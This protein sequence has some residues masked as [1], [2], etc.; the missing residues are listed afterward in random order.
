MEEPITP[1]ITARIRE[2]EKKFKK[3]GQDLG[4]H[5]DGLLHDR[6]LTY[7]DYIRLDTLLS[8]QVP[9]THFPDE[10]I[11]I[12]YHQI[13]ELYFKLVINELKQLI[14]EPT[15]TVK[16]FTERIRRVNRYFQV[17]T[18]SFEIMIK[19]MDREQFLQ[20]RL[21][22]MPASGFQSAQFR[23]IEIYTTPLYHLVS[24]ARRED[25]TIQS[26]LSEVYEQSYWK[27][28]A[29][30]IATGEKTLTLRQFEERYTPRLLRIAKEVEQSSVYHK[31]LHLPEEDRN[32]AK[33]I[34][35]LRTYDTNVN[36][37][38]LLMHMSAAYRHLDKGDEEVTATGGTNWKKFLPP[39]FQKIS[40]F[41]NL[42]NEN[43]RANWGKEWV[44]HLF[45]PKKEA[46]SN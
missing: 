35:E 40:F 29:T 28:G 1:E 23:M 11:F 38:W 6:Y 21:S 27:Y 12:T 44:H 46:L 17:L 30:D 8:L 25:F 41:P 42:W 9:L 45:H 15:P 24:D 36:V 20:F 16:F 32:N 2:L 10:S 7:W 22:L 39:S 5:L 26:P 13:T 34:H 37:N 33:L 31:Y 14:D 4:A 43:E 3:S 18:D 19:G